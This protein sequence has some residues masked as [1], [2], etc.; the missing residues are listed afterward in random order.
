MHSRPFS[1]TQ[2]QGVQHAHIKPIMQASLTSTKTIELNPV[3]AATMRLRTPKNG[4]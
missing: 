4:G 3:R 1:N 2:V